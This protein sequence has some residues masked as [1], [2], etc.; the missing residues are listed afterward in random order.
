MP[1]T[2]FLL[3]CEFWCLMKKCHFSLLEQCLRLVGPLLGAIVI[4]D[5][6]SHQ[7]EH[8]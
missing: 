8:T 1:L 3:F 6:F 7:H 2:D 5:N 4:S